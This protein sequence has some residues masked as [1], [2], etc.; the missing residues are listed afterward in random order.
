MMKKD[1][2]NKIASYIQGHPRRRNF[3]GNTNNPVKIFNTVNEIMIDFLKSIGARP[4]IGNAHWKQ[5][6][7]ANKTMV[8]YS[9]FKKYINDTL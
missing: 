3:L 4:F 2:L 1:N 5:E 6:Q 8:Y 7:N 9:K